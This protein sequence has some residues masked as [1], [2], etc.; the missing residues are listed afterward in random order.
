M[1]QPDCPV[2]LQTFG[3]LLRHGYKLTGFCRRCSV[4][5]DIDLT[6]VPGDRKYVG[7]RFK[8]RACG[9]RVE[10]TLSPVS[11]GGGADLPALDRWRRG[12]SAVEATVISVFPDLNV[13]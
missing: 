12:E 4:H 11:T 6:A 3:D 5:K 9:S 1:S 8:C 10:I 7:S 2:S 13:T